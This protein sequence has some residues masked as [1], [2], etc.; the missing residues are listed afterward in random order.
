MTY[1]R[2]KATKDRYT[3]FLISSKSRYK[4]MTYER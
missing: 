1:K 4:S 3:W 2:Q